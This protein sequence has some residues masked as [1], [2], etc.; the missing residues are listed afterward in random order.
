VRALGE[1]HCQSEL[2]L[3]H[4]CLRR[5]CGRLRA[6]S[7]PAAR[8]LWTSYFPQVDAVVYIVDT[9]DR[10][11]FPEAK[12]ELDVSAVRLPGRLVVADRGQVALS[13]N[14]S[15]GSCVAEP[16]RGVHC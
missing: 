3:H 4:R 7:R 16:P 14:N 8:K 1:S 12:K 11:R 6:L 10:E 15:E 9:A 13:R 5:R 2:R